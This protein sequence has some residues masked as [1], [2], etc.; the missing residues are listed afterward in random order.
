MLTLSKSLVAAAIVA[1]VL[2][3]AN[4]NQSKV[5]RV[6]ECQ[7]KCDKDYAENGGDIKLD[8]CEA[9]CG[10]EDATR[11]VLVGKLQDSINTLANREDR[12]EYNA[13]VLELNALCS[14][15]DICSEWACFRDG[16]ANGETPGIADLGN[17]AA[18]TGLFKSCADCSGKWNGA[19]E[20]C[21]GTCQGTAA[22]DCAGVCQGTAVEDC[23]GTCQGTAVEDCAGTCAGTALEDC[24]GICTEDAEFADCEGTCKGTAV[25]DCEGTCKGT[26][27]EDVCKVCGGSA[28]EISA[29]VTV[30]VEEGVQNVNITSA[31]LPTAVSL[32]TFFVA[33]VA[34]L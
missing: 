8:L 13:A 30:K 22:E 6:D 33:A 12:T 26:A 7:A 11:D 2:T 4:A 5:K 29:C 18:S 32:L 19:V 24:E 16:V 28:T 15:Y 27:V 10:G 23:A 1:A 14:D 9:G 34:Q 20:D 31:A 25:E 3:P 17:F 21:A